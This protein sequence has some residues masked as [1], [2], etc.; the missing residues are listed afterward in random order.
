M[1][2]SVVA[3][4]KPL[5]YIDGATFAGDFAQRPFSVHH[6]LVDHPLLSLDAIAQLADEMPREAVERHR[7]DL[8]MFMP[9]GAPEL[10]GSPSETVREI[11]TNGCWMVLW[12]IEQIGRYR[13]LLDACLDEVERYVT[14]EHG[15]MRDRKAY[16]FLSAPNATT[17]VHFDPEHNLLLQ[18]R[19]IKDMSVGRFTDPADQQRELDR[20]HGGG[21][22]NLDKMPEEFALF[23]MH[24]GEGVYVW[25]F[26]PHWVQNS[27]E[28]SVSL[29]IT[30]RTHVSW[31]TER[32][33]RFNARLRRL[34]LSPRPAGE[35]RVADEAKATVMKTAARLRPHR[36][37]GR[38]GG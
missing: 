22:R 30:F 7:A 16:L 36:T 24:P 6:S 19:G 35:S 32:V 27:G 13:A 11:E 14:D 17:P 26:A 38:L 21:H 15:G 33:H 2:G 1:S 34:H 8:P 3:A 9:G 12:N 28:A 4:G 23:R 29:S 18:I 37:S 31:R 25:P 10:S 20:Y 5:L